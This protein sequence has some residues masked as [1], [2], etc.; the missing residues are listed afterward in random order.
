MELEDLK[1]LLELLKETDI[2]ELQIE[3]DGSKVK[4]KREKIL[5]PIGMPVQ[6]SSVYEEKIVAETDD[7][8]QRLVTVTSPI[9]GT[10]YRAPSPEAQSFVEVGQSVNKGMVLCIVEAMKLMNEIESDVD[11]IIVKV[12]VENSQPV[13]YGEPLFL[14]EP[15]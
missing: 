8:I 7:E 10:F 4:I 6:K 12:L 2:T 9:V 3:K 15:Q 13:E 14:I 11:G 1:E 5:S